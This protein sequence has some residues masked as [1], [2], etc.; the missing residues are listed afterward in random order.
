MLNRRLSRK[1]NTSIPGFGIIYG[2]TGLLGV[3][4]CKRR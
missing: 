3:F 4:F 1:K 2:I